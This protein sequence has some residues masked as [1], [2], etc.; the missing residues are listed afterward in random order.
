MAEPMPTAQRELRAAD[1][2]AVREQLGREPTTPFTVVSR[3]T[4][5]HPLVIRNV[6]I[7]AA[8]DPFPTTFW[9]TCPEAVKAV[10][11]VES[12]GWIGR[13]NER[14][15]DDEGFRAS[16]EAAH[17]A[18]A[19][20]RATDLAAARSWGGVA[21]TRVG[22]KC[23]HAHYAYRLAGGD[24][25]VGAWV[26][27]RVEPVHA[28]QRLGRVGAIDQGT[29]SIR[30]LVVEPP[31]APGV[32]A[33]ELARDMLI[34]RLGLGVDRTGRFDPDALAR[35]VEALGMFCRRAQALGAERIRVGATSAVRDAENRGEYAA[36]VRAHAGSDLEVITGE[37]EAR[38]SFL[39]G[40]HGLDPAW[41][42]FAVQDIG[43]GSTEF[44]VGAAPGIAEQAISTRMGSVRMTERHV[45]HDPLTAEDLAALE[46]DVA[47]VLEEVDTAVAVG[48]ARTFVAVAGTAT[49]LQAIAL[50]L[51]RYDPDRI[52]R[53]WLTR[54]QAER[55]RDAL[56]AMTDAERAA[57]PVMAPGRG[58]VIVA[59]AVILV[60]TMR[61]FGVDRV[62][63]SESDILDGLALEMLGPR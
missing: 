49:T 26:A 59:G 36:A 27:E 55:V 13:L 38:L 28:E 22:I 21:G 48:D 51:D 5:G 9:L 18:Y 45:R 40:T 39:G 14:M 2:S 31:A 57:L 34:T 35:T 6:P 44:V 33:T 32:S 30:L 3:C 12:E 4:G 23:L 61:R 43:G 37:Q 42:P 19:A 56:A 62:L 63:V 20:E 1:V 16:V 58:D 29:N 46:A 60:A 24:D 15:A 25:P 8:G 11:R 10:S 52:H 53:T 47:G 17:D 7:D 54:E 41:G 50:E